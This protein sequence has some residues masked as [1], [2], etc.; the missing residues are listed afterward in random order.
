M[1]IVSQRM[2]FLYILDAY[3]NKAQSNPGDSYSKKRKKWISVA[4]TEIVDFETE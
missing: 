3:R 2:T 1:V 4:I